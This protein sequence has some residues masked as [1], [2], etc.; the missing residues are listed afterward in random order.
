MGY[1]EHGV[2]YYKG[3]YQQVYA[4]P[5]QSISPE[6]ICWDEST[7]HQVLVELI[8]GGVTVEHTVLCF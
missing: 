6:L 2:L 5:V 7:D 4:H 8:E 3:Y 1:F